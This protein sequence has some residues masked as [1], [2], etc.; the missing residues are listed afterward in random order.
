MKFMVSSGY[1]APEYI[2]HGRFSEKTDVYSFGVLLLEIV[3][4]KENSSF[5]LEEQEVG[6]IAFVSRSLILN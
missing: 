5:Y 6:L 1:M 4:G 3:S 2:L